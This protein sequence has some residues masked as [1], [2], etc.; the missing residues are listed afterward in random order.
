MAI[1]RPTPPIRTGLHDLLHAVSALHGARVIGDP[2]TVVTGVAL[3]SRQ[4]QPGDLYAALPGAHTHGGAYAAAV[5]DRAAAILT[6]PAGVA[7]V[8]EQG[9]SLPLLVADDPRAVLGEVS[10]VVYGSDRSRPTMIGVTGTNGKTTTAHLIASALGALGRSHGLIGTVEMRIGDERITSV[11]TTPEACDLHALL[12]VMGRRGTNVCVMEVSSHAL[13][14]HRVDGVVYDVALFMNLSQDH[15][16]YHGTMEAYFAAKARLFTPER[17]RRGVVCVEDDWG[18][19]L[20]ATARVPVVT[21]SST[22][23]ADWRIHR[24]PADAEAFRLAGPGAE[25]ELRTLLP[26]D[27]N[28]VNTAMAALALLEIGVSGR[29]V[30]RAILTD[31]HVP[32]RMEPVVPTSPDDRGTVPRAV[33][34][35]AHTPD[36][37]TAVLS[38]LRPTTPGRLVV[39]LGAGGERDRAKR[40][41]MGRAAVLGA[42][43]VV[44]TDDN[45]RSELP[46]DIRAAVLSGARAVGGR[47]VLREV[48]DRADAIRAGVALAAEVPGSTVAVLGKGHETTQDVGGD[49]RPFDDRDH[50][51]R[52]LDDLVAARAGQTR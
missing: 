5:A 36:A 16:D 18:R 10:R 40:P 51:Q 52:A 1:P 3:D 29:D 9:V 32:G 21:L 34:D 44:V 38:A 13:V 28:I 24:D 37:V 22:G 23:D 25:L 19:R 15:L 17:A 7:L 12:A 27:F 11:R 4:V 31:P 33:V 39:V 42:D 2:A 14:Q 45:P 8:T 26:G 47:T 49:R 41:A 43:A 6:D 30:E 20:A 48:P 35:Y 50:L 46:E